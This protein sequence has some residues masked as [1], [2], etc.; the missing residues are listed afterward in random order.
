[1]R[2]GDIISRRRAVFL[3]FAVLASAS[4]GT[5]EPAG[6]RPKTVLELDF[7][8]QFRE[9][10]DEGEWLPATVPGCIHT[11]LLAAGV[12]PDPFFGD[13]EKDLQWI[14]E[15]K[16][17]Y[18]CTFTADDS[19]LMHDKIYITFEGLDTY[20][21]AT[22]NGKYLFNADNMFLKWRTNIKSH[23]KSGENYLEIR[24][25]AAGPIEAGKRSSLGYGLPGGDRV[26]TRKAAYHYG[27]DWGPRYVTCGVWR[28][29]RITGWSDTMIRNLIATTFALSEERAIVNIG[30]NVDFGHKGK[31]ELIILDKTRGRRY[32]RMVRFT[33]DHE[34]NLFNFE[35]RIPDPQFWWPAGLGSQALQ[36]YTA[37]IYVDNMLI[38]SAELCFGF[39][40]ME[41]VTD[42]DAEGE[43]FYLKINGI[44]VFMKGANWIPMDSFLPR[45]GPGDYRRLLT[46]AKD[47]N[48]NM[49]RVWGGGVYEDE[50]FYDLC[51]SLGIVV[52]QD[53]MFACA[54]YP[55]DQEFIAGSLKEARQN[56]MRLRG[57]PCL[58]LWCGN[59]ENNEGWHNWGW[60]NDYSRKQCGEIRRAYEFLFGIVLP[61]AVISAD[62]GT[63]EHIR[64]YHPSS[65]RYGRAD[66]KS[67]TEGDA[68]YW[69]VWHDAEPFEILEDRIP[70]FMSEFGF[71]SLPSMKT[72]E[73]FTG[74]DERHLE[75]EAMQSHQKHPR[76]YELIR[77]Y[78]E[79]WYRVPEK[80]EDYIYVSQLLQAEGMR[81]GLTAQRRAMPYCMGTLYWQLNDCWPAVSWSSINFSGEW[82]ALHYAVK[83][84]FEPVLVSTATED[85]MLHLYI[86]SDRLE[87]IGGWMTMRL[88]GFDGTV[89]WERTTAVKAPPNGSVKVFSIPLDVLLSGADRSAVVFSAE[90]TCPGEKPPV[91]IRYFVHPKDMK[92]PDPR[93][94][95]AIL[96][97][98]PG[99]IFTMK[100]QTLVKNLFLQLDGVHFSDNFFDIL[101]GETVDVTIETDLPM[102][103]IK[104]RL[105]IKTLR[106]TY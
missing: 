33:R 75:S 10:G 91:A 31:A 11:D 21:E 6:P 61:N 19:L 3:L 63:N 23:L 42:K 89:L 17:V 29:V 105:R 9:A 64:A 2:I 5:N 15:K 74:P 25:R 65:P 101:P 52:W 35:F 53:F 50:I 56:I 44:P 20:A 45:P 67:L 92:L 39:R 103:E 16:W 106:D 72:V 24:F 84:A 26:F 96:H 97:G 41:L 27:W 86:V 12:I 71:Q 98:R 30:I 38:D 4:C 51:D 102:R 46:A 69:G 93:F 73:M 90:F 14:G 68:H 49:L 104:D 43:S 28:P 99:V 13:N 81:I 100:A 32:S 18:A 94:K 78:M 82:K 37:E 1:M 54:M 57:H 62:A 48:M 7:G 95:F 77:E 36:R 58:A 8:W 66:P 70:R 83:R 80:F 87:E 76:G 79:R 55:G 34:S 47:A 40:K 22:L 59:N 88:A 60:Q 85:G